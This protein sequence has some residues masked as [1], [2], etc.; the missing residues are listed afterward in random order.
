MTQ[1]LQ[2]LLTQLTLAEKASL[3][4]GANAWQTKAIPRLGIPALWLSDGPH[5]LRVEK[6]HGFYQSLPAT[7][8][9]TA[10][11]LG[12]TWN[13]A[14]LREVGEAIGRE[15]VAQGVHVVLGPGVNIK[16]S[17][18]GGR[19][20]EYYSEDPLLSGRLGAAFVRG[21]QSQGVGA[22]PKH[23]TANNQETLRMSV[24]SEVDER[25]LR[26]IY[27]PAFE[28]LVREAQPWTMMCAYNLVNGVLASENQYLLHDILRREW[29][30]EGIVLSDW[31]AVHDRVRGLAAGL[32]LE[33]PGNGGLNDRKL[34]AAVEAGHLPE[35]RL[36]EIVGEILKLIFKTRAVQADAEAAS[37]DAA[38]HHRLAQR[39]SA[40]SICLLKNE[41]ALLPLATDTKVAVIGAFAQRARYQGGGSSKVNPTREENLW[42]QLQTRWSDAA[43]LTF[44]P[45]YDL[46]VY[47]GT[48]EV[49]PERRRQRIAEAVAT[50]KAA[51][52]AL[53][54]LGLPDSY[55]SESADR[56]HLDLP[57]DQNELLWQLLA[58]QSEVVVVLVNGSAVR[59]PWHSR[60]KA[61]VEA[62]LGGQAG[63]AAL[64]EVLTG[65]VNP[66]GRLAETFPLQLADTP[67]Y[68]HFPGDGQK[69]H[70]GEGIFV[71]YRYYD[72]KKIAPLF[73]FGHGLSYTE[74]SYRD[75]DLSTRIMSDRDT[76]DLSVRVANVGDREGAEVVQLYVRARSSRL[77]RPEKELRAFQKVGLAAGEER[78]LHFQ[79]TPRDFAY[80]DPM[81]GAWQVEAGHYDL[82]LGASSR[83]LRLTAELKIAAPHFQ[84]PPLTV[85]T[86]LGA[87]IDHPRGGDLG[88][89]TLAAI[90]EGMLASFGQED[91]EKLRESRVFFTAFLLD[92]PLYKLPALTS[93]QFSEA[94]V[95]A[96]LAAAQTDAI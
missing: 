4:S 95:A 22:C 74:F 38:A 55:E 61:I 36:D 23:F 63:A 7:C 30:Y 96:L 29:G 60:A 53:V 39:V 35:A 21:V 89:Q 24:S 82:H 18:L 42:E 25:S 45:G 16:R 51:D 26:E 86:T 17:P 47:R 20:F 52:L 76:L 87:L 72:T 13:E 70:Y 77:Q 83:D 44:A 19:N 81:L 90:L 79:L 37:W 31:G 41:A 68:L 1:H 64:A 59:M 6:A 94:Q 40:E 2:A 71:G 91:P 12:A 57:E 33:M 58:V 65:A 85:Y 50:A 5:G 49:D 48:T 73:P 32:H 78:Q 67:S 10:S 93:G 66:S 15:A 80:Y 84:Y 8:F 69:V 34:I 14:L 75:L 43:K 3:C 27:L 92:L 11:A 88:Q 28:Y 56:Q 54:V 62:W 46:E 9:P